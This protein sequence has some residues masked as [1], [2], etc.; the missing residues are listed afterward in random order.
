MLAYEAM[1]RL[2][3]GLA[4]LLAAAATQ[5]ADPA[6]SA[7]TLV[8]ARIEPGKSHETCI[9]LAAG[10]KRNWYWKSDAPVDFVIHYHDRGVMKDLVARTRMRG[11]GGTFIAKDEGAYCW[12]WTAAKRAKVE[13]KIQ[14]FR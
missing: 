12:V 2:V 4:A 8:D 3:A 9:A 1:M 13:G 10:E 14:P 5:A 11:D 6:P 7:P